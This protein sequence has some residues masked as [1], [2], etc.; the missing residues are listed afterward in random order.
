MKDF[1]FIIEEDLQKIEKNISGLL[2]SENQIMKDL[3]SF[4]K[5]KSK[6]IRSIFSILYLKL[7]N[8]L[9]TDDIIKLLSAGELIHNASLLHDDVI[10]DADLRRGS[11]TLSNKYN[12]KIAILSGDYLLSFAVEYLSQLNNINILNIFV[13][14]TKLMSEAEITQYLLRDKEVS[15]DKY[16]KIIYGKTASLFEG[17]LK[18]SAILSG[19]DYNRAAEF[20]K[21]FGLLFQINNDLNA[22]SFENDK[23]N[24]VKTVTDILG[25]EKTN[26]LKDNYKEKMRAYI[27]EYSENQY[28]R[29]LEDLISLL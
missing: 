24:G 12:S 10:D 3:D 15:L 9:I 27:K 26:A 8:A 14:T 4:I 19:I 13:N 18:S 7:N 22:D 16:L 5:E 1:G 29:G 25:I 6:R 17:V 11:V 23:K 2:I 20:G 28:K 21:N